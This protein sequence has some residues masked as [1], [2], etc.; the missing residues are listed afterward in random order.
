[1][2]LGKLKTHILAEFLTGKY[3]QLTLVTDAKTVL[4]LTQ[5]TFRGKPARD[6]VVGRIHLGPPNYKERELLKKH[7]TPFQIKREFK[8]VRRAA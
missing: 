7:K 2:R 8:S 6:R 3:Q 5:E 1:M 4:R